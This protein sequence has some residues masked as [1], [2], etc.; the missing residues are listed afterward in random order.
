MK[1]NK[2]PFVTGTDK[3][4]MLYIHN[5]NLFAKQKKLYS[6]FVKGWSQGSYQ[7][8]LNS[9]TLSSSECFFL[10][11]KGVENTK[12]KGGLIGMQKGEQETEK[13]KGNSGNKCDLS[14]VVIYI[15]ANIINPLLHATNTY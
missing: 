14:R 9:C 10:H 13:K 7:E 15:C 3:E 5:D 2:I 4:H 11:A 1:L 8:K 12:G 6:W